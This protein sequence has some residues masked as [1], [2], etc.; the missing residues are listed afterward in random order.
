MEFVFLATVFCFGVF[1]GLS[2]GHL[3][4]SRACTTLPQS[5]WNELCGYS[6]S[7]AA[8]LNTLA[9]WHASAADNRPKRSLTPAMEADMAVFVWTIGESIARPWPGMISSD[10]R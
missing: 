3:L 1:I 8:Q 7:S 4:T 2:I 5:Q 6:A 9:G 10:R